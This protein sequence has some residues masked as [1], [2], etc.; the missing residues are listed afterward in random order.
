MF[1]DAA[2]LIRNNGIIEINS[3]KVSESNEID[4]KLIGGNASAE[5]A[6]E[7]AEGSEVRGYDLA[8]QNR[9]QEMPPFDKKTYMVSF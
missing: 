6:A 4:D 1:T 2:N 7:G 8:I 9:L 5:E 3:K